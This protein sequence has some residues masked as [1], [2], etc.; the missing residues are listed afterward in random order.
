[1]VANYYSG[2]QYGR[3]Q[4]FYPGR[5]N[6]REAATTYL[7]SCHASSPSKCSTTCSITRLGIRKDANLAAFLKQFK[8]ISYESF[9]DGDERLLYEG[10]C[11]GSRT[12]G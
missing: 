6:N 9:E 5:L 12:D 7:W 11:W 3:T 2:S 8:E 10:G 1:M 4:L